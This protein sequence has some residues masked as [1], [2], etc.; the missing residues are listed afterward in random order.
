MSTVEKA[1]SL[2]EHFDSATPEL[3]L[4]DLTRLSGFDKATTRRLLVALGT[5]GIVEQDGDSK[6][7]RLGPGLVRFARLREATFP[8][9]GTARPIVDELSART[10]ETVHVSELASNVL[11]TVYVCESTKANRVSVAVGQRLPFNCTASGFAVLA[12]AA[13]A[14][15]QAV[16]NGPLPAIT[17]HSIT[18]S[19]AL[20]AQI[21]EGRRQGYTTCD[22]GYE[23]GVY[24]IAAPILSSSG[25]AFGAIS[26]ASPAT[27][28]DARVIKSHGAAARDAAQHIAAAMGLRQQPK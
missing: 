14:L 17:S 7:Y 9:V 15:R 11:S 13:D 18:S 20:A 8:F 25:Q 5:S 24:S 4:S 22:Q 12:F 16:L 19:T 3:G 6:R 10:G 21:A 28:I 26:I 1:L 2:L 23:D 27:R